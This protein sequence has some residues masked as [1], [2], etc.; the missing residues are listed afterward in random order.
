MIISIDA[1][2]ASDKICHPF[3]IKTL[4]RDFPGGPVVMNL[5]CK[6]GDKG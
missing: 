4:T 2:K 3:M 5:P 1:D 6:I